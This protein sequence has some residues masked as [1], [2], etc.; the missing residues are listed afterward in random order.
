MKVYAKKFVNQINIKR[1]AKNNQLKLKYNR[2]KTF[3]LVKKPP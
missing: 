2:L 1:T 3:S